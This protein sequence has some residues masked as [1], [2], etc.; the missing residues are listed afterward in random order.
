[1]TPSLEKY[2]EKDKNK[3]PNI[4]HQSWVTADGVASLPQRAVRP[5]G[6]VLSQKI[7]MRI[8]SVHCPL[9][10]CYLPSNEL[11]ATDDGDDSDLLLRFR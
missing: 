10:L 4:N 6:F 2:C 7:G 9:P 5:G 11:Q 8:S 1:M 3:S